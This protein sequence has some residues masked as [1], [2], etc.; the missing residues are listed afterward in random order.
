M[1]HTLVIDD[2][3]QQG[4]LIMELITTIK[5]TEDAVEF[6][7]EELID[8]DKAFDEALIPAEEVFDAFKKRLVSEV[9]RKHVKV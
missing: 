2:T 4:R 8:V 7:E 6:M 3:T 1:K 5:P 9:K